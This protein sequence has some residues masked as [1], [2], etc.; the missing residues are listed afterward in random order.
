MSA[1]SGVVHSE[2]NASAKDEVHL[3]Q[4]WITP[5]TKNLKPV[6]EQHL[7]PQDQ[8]NS[9]LVFPVTIHQQ[10]KILRGRLTPGHELKYSLSRGYGAWVQLISGKLSVNGHSLGQGDAAMVENEPHL[11]FGSLDK[12]E[13]LLFDLK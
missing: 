11:Q 6:Y 1:G 3:L 8:E 2:F 7:L 12:C 10:A 9:L 4:I 13:F 5:D